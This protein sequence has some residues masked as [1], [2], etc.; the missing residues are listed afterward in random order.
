[1]CFY[2][3]GGH[4]RAYLSIPLMFFLN[5]SFHFSVSAALV[6]DEAKVGWLTVFGI[7]GVAVTLEVLLEE[8]VL[9]KYSNT[10][11]GALPY[12]YR[13]VRFLL[14]AGTL[15]AALYYFI[16]WCLRLDGASL[17]GRTG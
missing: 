17:Y 3:L 1:M 2:P 16:H 14:A 15:R 7:L 9:Q 13:I 5:A 4:A 8:K 11:E 12:W 10:S 6:K